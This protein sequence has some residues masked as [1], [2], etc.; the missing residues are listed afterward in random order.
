MLDSKGD[1]AGAT[2]L[3]ARTL[4]IKEQKYGRD[5]PE[6]AASLENLAAAYYEQGDYAEA[7]PLQRRSF[8]ILSRALPPEHPRVARAES[9]LGDLLLTIGRP[10][11]ARKLFA[12]SAAAREKSLGPNHP[13]TSISWQN[14]AF[15]A[16]GDGDCS[17]AIDAAERSAAWLADAKAVGQEATATRTRV[18]KALQAADPAARHAAEEL[19]KTR[20]QIASL[21]LAEPKPADADAEIARLEAKERRFILSLGLAVESLQQGDPWVGI[22]TIRA[23][24]PEKSVLID[25]ARFRPRNFAFSAREGRRFEPYGNPRYVAWVIP[26]AG[27][28]RV[29]VV[30][31]GEAATIEPLVAEYRKRIEDA[32]EGTIFKEGQA[33]AQK[34]LAVVAAPLAKRTIEPLLAAAR[35]AL[36]EDPKELVVCPDGQ[37]WLTPFGAL[38]LAD[39]RFAIEAVAIRHLTSSR[40]IA[41]KNAPPGDDAARSTLPPLIMAAPNFDKPSAGQPAQRPADDRSLAGPARPAAGSVAPSR[42][43]ARSRRPAAWRRPCGGSL[44]LPR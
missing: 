34:E 36:G 29:R 16:A 21:Q 42:C 33:T 5:S 8:E 10:T 13:L 22:D 28:G 4:T 27:R 38:V 43:R 2:K 17:A 18:Q 25:I 12:E 6:A 44:R 20:R 39:G 7:E 32:R 41:A 3:L 15:A 19:M 24:L 23:A 1:L 35:D 14:L 40:D 11:E 31:L 26:P 30:D 9:N 37:L